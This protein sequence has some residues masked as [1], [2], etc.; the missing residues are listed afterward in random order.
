MPGNFP[1]SRKDMN[2][3]I[4][5]AQQ[6]PRRM[7]LKRSTLRNIVIKLPDPKTKNLKAAGEKRILTYKGSSINYQ[8]I[9][10]EKTSEARREWID[11]FKC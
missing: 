10:H 4:R 8:Q 6:T 2:I 3:D 7:N 5:E 1:N 9:F 11:T